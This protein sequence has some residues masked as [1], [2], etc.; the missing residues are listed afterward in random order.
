MLKYYYRWFSHF[1]SINFLPRNLYEY[2]RSSNVRPKTIF[3]C[4]GTT[5]REIRRII[6]YQLNLMVRCSHSLS[7]KDLFWTYKLQLTKVHKSAAACC[8][9]YFNFQLFLSKFVVNDNDMRHLA[10]QFKKYISFFEDNGLHRLTD[11][12]EVSRKVKQD[13]ANTKNIYNW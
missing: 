8:C 2:L 7:I 9:V 5:R 6:H 11:F 1:L 3:P 4:C 12:A 13:V 10:L